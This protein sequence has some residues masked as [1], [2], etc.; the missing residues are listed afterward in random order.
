MQ[1][2]VLDNYVSDAF[3]DQL[4]E[5]DTPN[6]VP[7]EG[8]HTA[9]DKMEFEQTPHAQRMVEI[10]FSIQDRVRS[11]D[12]FTWR[13]FCAGQMRIVECAISRYHP[14]GV[15]FTWHTDYGVDN[16]ALAWIV[17]LTDTGG[18]LEIAHAGDVPVISLE[19]RRGR[20]IVFP[21]HYP[22]RVC[23]SDEIRITAHG[24]LNL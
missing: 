3:V 10:L 1:I 5:L 23:S 20:L 11:F 19:P 13:T 9:R 15:G 14:G 21:V 24:H 6:K 12:D 18:N 17:N 8:E 7:P 4:L 16:R 2:V 22:H